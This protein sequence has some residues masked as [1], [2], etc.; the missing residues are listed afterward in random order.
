MNTIYFPAH[1]RGF[2]NHGWLKANHTFSFGHYFDPMKIGFGTIRVFNDDLIAPLKGFGTHS[3]EDME[4]VTIPLKGELTHKDSLGSEEVI[5]S[6]EVQRMSAGS[7]ISHSEYN[8]HQK[9]EANALQIWI[10]PKKLGIKPNYEQ[11]DFSLLKQHNYWQ[12]IVSPNGRDESLSINQD[13]FFS[14]GTFE[15][16]AV[17]ERHLSSNG[18]F[19]FVISGTVIIGDQSINARDGLGIINVDRVECNPSKMSEILIIEIPL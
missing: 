5:R 9:I 2:F 11:K 14:I 6:G 19:V 10:T 15:K 7:G 4:I 17:Y 1:E 13:A 18:V 12:L 8:N 3:H 16:K